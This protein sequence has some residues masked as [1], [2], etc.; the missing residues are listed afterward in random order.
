MAQ[1]YVQSVESH[2]CFE[3]HAPP[4]VKAVLHGSSFFGWIEEPLTE[5]GRW[6]RCFWRGFVHVGVI[7]AF[8]NLI[9]FAPPS[10]SAEYRFGLVV[11]LCCWALLSI[12]SYLGVKRGSEMDSL[13]NQLEYKCIADLG[14]YHATKQRVNKV[15]EGVFLSSKAGPAFTTLKTIN[16]GLQDMDVTG[17]SNGL[18]DMD[19]TGESNGAHDKLVVKEE[20]FYA[21]LYG[22]CLTV[23]LCWLMTLS[24]IIIGA[25]ETATGTLEGLLFASFS[26]LISFDQI[27]TTLCVFRWINVTQHTIKAWT[28]AAVDI[29]DSTTAM[30]EGRTGLRDFLYKLD[31]LHDMF[32]TPLTVCNQRWTLILSIM[33]IQ[34]VV[35]IVGNIVLIYAPDNTSTLATSLVILLLL[36]LCL[37]LIFESGQITESFIMAR[38]IFRRPRIIGALKCLLG[39]SEQTDVMLRYYFLDESPGLKLM[40]TTFSHYTSLGVM[41]TVFI[42]LVF[43]F[44]PNIA[45]AMI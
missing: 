18:Q 19:V 31:L 25:V 3:Y 9:V 44:G 17:E 13:L 37:F 24:I 20:L 12:Y 7:T 45:E 41:M 29:I 39:D 33:I 6:L 15:H 14:V 8:V 1:V 5:S 16:Q 22:P 43:S 4:L 32:N 36:F 28:Y 21:S 34:L 27:Y 23:V 11:L 2:D 35:G 38:E 26:M 30:E 10:L 42:G 40:G